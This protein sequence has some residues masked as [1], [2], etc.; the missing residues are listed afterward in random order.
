MY[1]IV[2]AFSAAQVDVP[3]PR[4]PFQVDL[5]RSDYELWKHYRADIAHDVWEDDALIVLRT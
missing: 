4:D 3:G 1:V 2:P 5:R